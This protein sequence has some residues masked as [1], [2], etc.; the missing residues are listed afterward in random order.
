M[1]YAFNLSR[2]TRNVAS[3]FIKANLRVHQTQVPIQGGNLFVVNHFTRIETLLLPYALHQAL[4]L[5]VRVLVPASWMKGHIGSFLRTSGVEA[6]AI[7]DRTKTLVPSLL[8]GESWIIFP[9]GYWQREGVITRP[10]DRQHRWMRDVVELARQVEVAGQSIS[11][12]PLNISYFPIRV[13]ENSL[14]TLASHVLR[15]ADQ[16]SLDEL[17]VEGTLLSKKTDIDVTLGPSIGV[18]VAEGSVSDCARRL[19]RAVSSLSTLNLDHLSLALLRY[20]PDTCFD[21][22]LFRQRLFMCLQVVKDRGECRLHPQ[23]LQAEHGLLTDE[24]YP[25]LQDLFQLCVEEGILARQ[26][27]S[28]GTRFCAVGSLLP[29]AGSHRWQA[30]AWGILQEM[31]PLRELSRLI[32]TISRLPLPELKEQIRQSIL[33]LDQRI[34]AEDYACYADWPNCKPRENAEPFLL[35]PVGIIRAGVVLVHGYMSA[36]Q[37]VRNLAEYLLAAGYAVYAVRLEGHGTVPEDL[38]NT[39]WSQWYAAVNRGYAILSTLTSKICLGGFSTGGVLA[40]LAAANK[41]KKITAVFAV[42]A[43]LELRSYVVRL[44]PTI[45]L[46]NSLWTALSG[47]AV[48][49][50]GYVENQSE[51]PDINY[52]RNPLAGIRQLGLVIETMQESLGQIQSDTLLMQSSQDPVVDDSSGRLIFDQVGAEHKE[53]ILFSSS[54][55]CVINGRDSRRLYVH[56]RGFLSSALTVE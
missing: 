22:S 53:L 15:Q 52:D 12:I 45:V 46:A 48:G 42:N 26:T 38:A 35:Q 36:P 1:E 10:T 50:W 37:E 28:E 41:P 6:E 54:R 8:C 20:L 56:I 34:L 49:Q 31:R 51:S 21:E 24:P 40:L 19:Y 30:L 33:L 29:R 14:L 11:V 18:S 16:E 3:H 55:H 5:N 32:R 39:C 7:H 47:G 43:P 9:T 25:P 23:L 17:T 27:T 44:V 13:R 4:G 2:W